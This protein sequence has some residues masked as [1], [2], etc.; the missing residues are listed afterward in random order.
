MDGWRLSLLLNRQIQRRTSLLQSCPPRR[1]AVDRLRKN[2]HHRA[3]VGDL[4]PV[5][6]IADGALLVPIITDTQLRSRHANTVVRNSDDQFVLTRTVVLQC[7]DDDAACASIYGVR[8]RLANQ[9]PGIGKI[10]RNLRKFLR[11]IY[12]GG[13]QV[14]HA[15][16][17][18]P[19]NR[20]SLLT[21]SAITRAARISTKKTAVPRHR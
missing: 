21:A 15:S 11:G 17:I 8:D 12:P 18:L 19:Q 5:S 10:L 14:S 9:L 20:L 6:L 4:G 16:L 7:L 3:V 2:S 13:V 1:A